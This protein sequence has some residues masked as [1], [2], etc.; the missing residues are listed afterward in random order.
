MIMELLETISRWNLEFFFNCSQSI[1]DNKAEFED[2]QT[3][4]LIDC[5]S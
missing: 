1:N 4:E 2:D 5:N 3:Q